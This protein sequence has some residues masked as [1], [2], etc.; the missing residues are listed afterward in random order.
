MTKKRAIALLLAL[1]MIAA[2]AGTA[3]AAQKNDD[4][5]FHLGKIQVVPILGVNVGHTSNLYRESDSERDAAIVEELINPDTDAEDAS[6]TDFETDSS[7]VTELNA[8]LNFLLPA[9]EFTF[10]A[11]GVAAWTWY[12]EDSDQ[13]SN[14]YRV[15]GSVGGDFPG[16]FS[17]LLKDTYEWGWLLESFEFGEGEDY[18]LNEFNADFSYTFHEDMRVRFQWVNYLFDY[19]ISDD[20]DRV[21]NI[22]TG[23]F[24]RRVAPKTAAL[25]AVDYAKYSYDESPELDNDSVQVSGGL[26]W[27]ATGRT[28]GLVQG[29]YEW[30]RYDTEMVEERDGEYFTVTVGVNYRPGQ[31]TSLG[32]TA[33]R[34]SVESDFVDNPYFVQSSVR[35]DASYRLMRRFTLS[36]W[37]E[38]QKDDYPNETILL[39]V[40]RE[41]EDDYGRVGGRLGFDV[42]SWL[43]LGVEATWTER[44]SNYDFFDYDESRVW[45]TANAGF[46]ADAFRRD[47]RR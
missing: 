42:L 10:G 22:L 15:F 46:S 18:T 31:K 33:N 11:G 40:T 7:T 16:G 23:T 17:F 36:A 47:R 25:L 9:D 24:Y 2:L 45:F 43:N 12:A 44:D 21:E 6:S 39:D 8:G 5:L 20:R 38:L 41:R 35:A 4:A 19:D 1:L 30:K 27:E 3:P 29:G 14:D 32:L 28:T 37:G 34:R 26:T 13:D